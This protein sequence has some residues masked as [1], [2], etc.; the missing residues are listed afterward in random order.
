MSYEELQRIVSFYYPALL[1]DRTISHHARHSF[2]KL[3]SI[4]VI[5][6]SC[7]VMMIRLGN[8]T[9]FLQS[10]SIL[11]ALVIWENQLVGIAF[12]SF[13]LWILFFMFDAMFHSLY[14]YAIE[15]TTIE[16]A[17][18]GERVTPQYEL[19]S[20][21]FYTPHHDF[22][23][24]FCASVY[25][26]RI[27]LRVGI[28]S[29]T[30]AVFLAHRNPSIDMR[31][32]SGPSQKVATLA[33]FAANLVRLDKEFEQ[34]LLSHSV[35]PED[36][37][38]TVLW[39]ERLIRSAK[40]ADRWWSREH[41]LAH[42]GMGDAFSFGETYSVDR[43]SRP[44]ASETIFAH[45]DESSPFGKEAEE[46]LEAILAKESAANA[47]LIGEAGVG[48]IDVV[49]RLE[50]KIERGHALPELTRKRV[51]IFDFESLI[52]ATSDKQTFERKFTAVM[53]QAIGAG[54][55]LL[56]IED[57]PTCMHSATSIG[58][59]VMEVLDP[60]LSGAVT[61]IIA[62]SNLEEFHQFLENNGNV[63]KYFN[64]VQVEE[65]DLGTVIRVLE[66]RAT[67]VERRSNILFTFPALRTIAESA[68]QYFPYGVMPDKAV[69]LLLEI[70]P[71]MEQKGIT[72]VGR[73]NVLDIITVKTGIPVGAIGVEE[74]KKLQDLE[75]LMQKRVVS[76][77]A[78]V[79]AIANA[80]R[81]VRSGIGNIN[82]PVGA[83]LFLGP[84]GVGKTETAKALAATY[85]GDEEKLLRLDMSEYNG[86]DSLE[87]LIGSVQNKRAGTLS[88]LVRE[89]P[90]GVLLLDEFEKASS[91][92]HNLFLQVFDE[93]FFSD[94][95]GKRVSMRNM[96]LIA[97]SNA[98]SSFI[99]ETFK[100]GEKAGNLKDQLIDTIIKE[101]IYRPELLNRFDEIVVFEPLG[102][103]SLR[104]IARNMLDTL[105]WKL[106]K[107]GIT[108]TVNDDLVEVLVREGYDPQFGARPMRRALQHT[109]EEAVAKKIIS[110][111][112]VAGGTIMLTLDE[113]GGNKVVDKASAV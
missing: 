109:I 11:H 92:V 66:D 13:G 4:I 70:I 32:L 74:K 10:V 87:R 57:L 91:D 46:K 83:F 41:L 72:V 42:P 69:D 104:I 23:A 1:L 51:L 45:I 96:I 99:W 50:K 27:L 97:T 15:R 89:S 40:S 53:N 30:I 12:M 26:R 105:Y 24:G 108:L 80:L 111:E 56:L 110:G 73:N 60:Y 98:G 44:L 79:A 85:F 68:D 49:A 18:E 7:T 59:D 6:C 103:D 36:L 75:V 61:Q 62:T 88:T 21:I 2:K 37:R 28:D 95:Y 48:K 107:K 58:V 22:V 33:Q 25:G 47:L 86:G 8:A 3:F 43:Y 31:K 29:A 81:R 16:D 76:Q 39:E 84:T 38:D 93:G 82:R 14:Y 9:V 52:S 55:I 34:F 65:A 77:D 71:E 20:V 67:D 17:L 63:M 19:A 101:K 54:N 5:L 113:L 94:M 106:Q 64:T 35:T 100:R 112:A 78:A 102:V 90:Y